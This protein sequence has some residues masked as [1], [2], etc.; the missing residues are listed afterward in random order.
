MTMINTQAL[1][2]GQML[3]QI[4]LEC[5]HGNTTIIAKE[6]ELIAAAL[7]NGFCELYGQMSQDGSKITI[8]DITPDFMKKNEDHTH[9]VKYMW[10]E[11][12]T[13]LIDD[14]RNVG[15]RFGLLTPYYV[16]K[17]NLLLA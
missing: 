11:T 16:D 8:P 13:S 5:L 14:V 12:Y 17:L 7:L 1:F 3:V 4:L 6:A 9:N 10:K 15:N 2:D